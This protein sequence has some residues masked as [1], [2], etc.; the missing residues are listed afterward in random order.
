MCSGKVSGIA[1]SRPLGEGG[2]A[3]GFDG[4]GIPRSAA[5]SQKAAMQMPFAV[6]IPSVNKVAQ[7][8]TQ[9]FLSHKL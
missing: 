2:K 6:T 1:Q 9:A 5:L 7:K 4:R 8:R 3:A